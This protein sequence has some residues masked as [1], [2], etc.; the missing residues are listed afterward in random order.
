MVAVSKGFAVAS[1]PPL[2]SYGALF[3]VLVLYAFVRRKGHSHEEA[4]DLT[5]GFFEKFLAK[6]YLAHVQRERGKFR[7]FLLT[8]L[9]HSDGTSS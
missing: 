3:S 1:E 5:Q 7:T 9:T 8:S 2:K 4:Q 6:D